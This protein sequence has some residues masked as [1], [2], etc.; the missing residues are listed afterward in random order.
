MGSHWRQ[1][2]G[3]LTG[4]RALVIASINMMQK[5][6][7]FHSSA[8]RRIRSPTSLFHPWLT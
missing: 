2:Q 4:T 1:R 5:G 8:P 6:C 3:K 7:G